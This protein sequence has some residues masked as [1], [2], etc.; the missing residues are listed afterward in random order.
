MTPNSAVMT[1]RLR[2]V[3]AD[4]HAIVCEG[5]KQIIG[6]DPA[7]IVI[8][9]VNTAAQAM[10][11]I[12]A[13]GVDILLLDISLPD[14]NGIELLKQLKQE[15]PSLKVLVCSLHHE[16]AYALRALRAGAAGYLSKQCAPA[17]LLRA[18]HQVAIGRKY[19]SAEL[20]QELADH[21]GSRIDVEPHQRL[22][23]REY[24]TLLKIAAGMTVTEIAAQLTL[25]VKTISMYR[26]RLLQKMRMRNNAELTHYAIRH[27]LL[28]EL[29][30]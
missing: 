23:D 29:T 13:G 27:Q 7:Y 2:V 24:Q 17:T 5:L 18:L 21:V 26:T 19:I 16:D 10:Q 12:R 11:M 22:S 25:S 14:R 8:A 20:A 1:S 6:S 3:I 9:E 30:E 15:T 28:P 4:D